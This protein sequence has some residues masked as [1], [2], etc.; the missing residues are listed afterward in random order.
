MDGDLSERFLNGLARERLVPEFP[1]GTSLDN[2][3]GRYA[4]LGN[5]IATALK[6]LA[7][8]A[9]RELATDLEQVLS[10]NGFA[11]HESEAELALLLGLMICGRELVDSVD[12]KV[13]DQ[14]IGDR[15]DNPDRRL[16]I[17]PH[18]RRG[19]FTAE[20][21]VTFTDANPPVVLPEFETGVAGGIAVRSPGERVAQAVLLRDNEDDLPKRQ[22][23]R[24]HV[25]RATGYQVYR[26]TREDVD[27]DPVG[28]AK[29]VVHALIDG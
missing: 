9:M 5:I 28:L 3:T 15:R 23:A 20:F 4:P 22:N 18:A 2:L 17:E 11:L 19:E 27:H 26:Y 25:F 21:L 1:P 16:L 29:R 7:A 14:L 24:H 10:A 13:E 6:P 8:Q 12:L